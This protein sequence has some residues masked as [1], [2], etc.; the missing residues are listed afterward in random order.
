VQRL[1]STFTKVIVKTR[2][3]PNETDITDFLGAGYVK[4]QILEIVF[5]V[6][7]KTL[8]NYTNHIAD[9]PVDKEFQNETWQ[10]S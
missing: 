4:E 10:P 6:A 9:T 1:L 5:F 8:T 2:G 7:F 3:Q